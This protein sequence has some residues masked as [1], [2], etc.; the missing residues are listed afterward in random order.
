MT[1]SILSAAKIVKKSLCVLTPKIK[2]VQ[3]FDDVKPCLFKLEMRNY[4]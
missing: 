3:K 1:L 2:Y 4:C